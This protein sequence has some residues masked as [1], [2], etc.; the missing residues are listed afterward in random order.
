MAPKLLIGGK[1]A[2][3]K[4]NRVHCI[5]GTEAEGDLTVLLVNQPGSRTDLSRHAKERLFLPVQKH[6]QPPFLPHLQIWEEERAW[7][8]RLHIFILPKYKEKS[9]R[10]N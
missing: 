10:E 4:V 3:P 2:S 8:E 6:F 5:Y 9:Q 7:K 1:E